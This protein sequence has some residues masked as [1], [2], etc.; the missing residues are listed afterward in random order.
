MATRHP[1]PGSMT[2]D[3]S[4]LLLFVV[5]GLRFQ[6]MDSAE[7]PISVGRFARTFGHVN[8]RTATATA[9]PAYRGGRCGRRHLRQ[10]QLCSAGTSRRASPQADA[11]TIAL[12]SGP[13]GSVSQHS[14]EAKS[15]FPSPPADL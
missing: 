3:P 14:P 5:R 10:V 13:P 1:A 9:A 11:S 2:V 8:A 12:R 6:H 4:Q 15:E 7:C